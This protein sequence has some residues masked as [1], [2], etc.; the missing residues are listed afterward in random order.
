[1]GRRKAL[2]HEVKE[3]VLEVDRLR[4]ERGWGIAKACRAVGIGTATYYRFKNNPES[5]P[6]GEPP[7]EEPRRDIRDVDENLRRYGIVTDEHPLVVKVRDLRRELAR[8]EEAVRQ[9]YRMMGAPAG[10][11]GSPAQVQSP[12]DLL[13][14]IAENLQ[15]IEDIKESLKQLLEKF[16]LKVEDRYVPREEVERLLEEERRKA[17]EE[18]L[19]DRRIQ[20]VENI[21]NRAVDRVTEMFKPLIQVW[22]NMILEG[23]GQPSTREPPEPSAEREKPELAEE[24][25]S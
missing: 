1:M 15:S 25:P 24:P 10:Q 7:R 18:A 21:I 4:K 6:R 19:D 17:V 20:A 2:Y 16:G 13:K 5:F 23:R 3:K 8:T 14:V 9:A 22:A 12:V 11:G